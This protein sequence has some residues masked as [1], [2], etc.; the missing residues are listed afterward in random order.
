MFKHLRI[1]ELRHDVNNA[2]N[3]TEIKSNHSKYRLM[4][5]FCGGNLVHDSFAGNNRYLSISL[6]LCVLVTI[7]SAL[8]DFHLQ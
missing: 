1:D 8:N 2:R 3:H 5:D 6:A 7:Q 4:S